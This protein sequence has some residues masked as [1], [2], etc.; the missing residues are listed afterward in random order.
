[1]THFLKVRDIQM[2]AL[3]AAHLGTLQATRALTDERYRGNCTYVHP[4]DN[5]CKCAIGESL[6]VVLTDHAT[7][8]NNMGSVQKLIE[9]NIIA[10][11]NPVQV[12]EIQC[13]HD[14]VCSDDPKVTDE[15]RAKRYKEFIDAL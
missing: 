9:K 12:L 8:L 10:V 11:D 3:K 15:E 6:P 7:N 4:A 1:M 13:L 2:N 14:A 5:K